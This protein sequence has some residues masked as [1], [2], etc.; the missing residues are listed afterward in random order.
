MDAGHSLVTVNEPL[1]EMKAFTVVLMLKSC[2]FDNHDFL[3]TK[4][5]A[6][7]VVGHGHSHRVGKLCFLF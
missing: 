1:F 3:F 4:P 6:S 7:L 5:G 2:F